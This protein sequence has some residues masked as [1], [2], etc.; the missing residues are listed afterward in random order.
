MLNDYTFLNYCI[1]LNENQIIFAVQIICVTFHHLKKLCLIVLVNLIRLQMVHRIM[2]YFY[3]FLK[4]H[5]KSY[6]FQ[7]VCIIG[8]LRQLQQQIV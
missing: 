8:E 6:M 3:V 4:K 5:R 2:I 7:N 1:V